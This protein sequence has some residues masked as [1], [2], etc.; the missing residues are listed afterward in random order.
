MTRAVGLFLAAFILCTGLLILVPAIDLTVSGWFYRPGA[1]FFLADWPPFRLAHVG[2]RYLVAAIIV[3]CLAA[4]VAALMRRRPFFGLDARAAIYLLLALAIGPG[5]VVN[6]MF[7]DHWGRAR[8]VHVVQFGGDE[9]FTPPFVPS[10]QCTTRNCSFPAGDP[11]VGFYFLAAAFLIPG[12][13]RRRLAI[14]GALA[15]GA[16]FGLVRIAQGGH[17]LSDVA[18]SG[19]LVAAISWSLWESLI[20]RDG[21]AALWRNLRDPPPALK[22]FASFAIATA[23]LGAISYAAIDRPLALALE[24]R[25]ALA[26]RVFQF[27]T[28]F[29]KSGG[30]LVAAAIIAVLCWLAARRVADPALARRLTRHAGESAFIFATVALSG[31][32]ADLLKPVFGRA[33]PKLLFADHMFG[34]TGLGAHADHWSFPSGHTVTAASLAA[35]LFLLYPRFWPAYLVAALL[36]AASRV[37]IDAH[38]LSDVIGGAFLGIAVTWAL[39][40]AWRDKLYRLS[41]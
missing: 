33:R 34:F 2:A 22:R 7:K 23:A 11:A 16:F 35:A 5:L 10:D 26:D 3:A 18:M 9:H 39:W 31:L 12:R 15:L 13:P 29:G 4:L 20:V 28:G 17:F 38:Y 27:I 8:P 1:G 41:P 36:V 25:G 19:F 37:A 30:W 14:A 24:N 32:I 40:A 6:A 21:L